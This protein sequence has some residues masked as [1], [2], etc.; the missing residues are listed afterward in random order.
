[1]VKF[2]VPKHDAKLII[3][4]VVRACSLLNL[5][6]HGS[7]RLDLSMDLTACHANGNP[8]DLGKLLSADN[9]NFTHDV[10]GIIHHIDRNTGG[11]KDFFSPRCSA[12]IAQH[13]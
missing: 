1:M 5:E 6:S 12:R 7:S 10:L 9:F 13:A 4:I 3:Q 11:L 8:I 2:D